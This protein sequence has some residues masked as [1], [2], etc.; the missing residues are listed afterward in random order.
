MFRFQKKES[1]SDNDKRNAMFQFQKNYSSNADDNEKRNAAYRF[2]K[3]D[4]GD[5]R[6]AAYRF[7]K[8][9]VK[10]VI[11]KMTREMACTDIKSK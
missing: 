8:K 6:N 5:K 7:Q 10:Q 9:K 3:K 4:N 1:E 2:Q 11:N